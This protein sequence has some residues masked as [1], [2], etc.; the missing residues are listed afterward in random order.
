MFHS[1]PVN[2]KKKTNKG[3]NSYIKP[4][5]N[6]IMR[7]SFKGGDPNLLKELRERVEAGELTRDQALVI[8]RG[9]E[10]PN[11]IIET[12][13]SNVDRLNDIRKRKEAQ[14]TERKN[15]V[16]LDG[17]LYLISNPAYPEWVKIG[18]TTDYEKRLQNY[19]TSSPFADYQMVACKW[20]ENSFES[21]QEFLSKIRLVFD[22]RGEWIKAPFTELIKE[23]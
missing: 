12:R 7:Y 15:S 10:A 20:V 19:Q 4:N 5:K 14:K 9:G 1:K 13:P 23:F 18:Q 6:N 3:L 11:D 17:F 2:K 22:V 8:L 21:E 16:I